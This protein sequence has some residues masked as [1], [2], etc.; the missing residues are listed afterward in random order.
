MST[1]LDAPSQSSSSSSHHHHRPPPSS[2]LAA[3]PPEPVVLT[4]AT[5]H[6]IHS[7]VQRA[8]PDD[9]ALV[10][11]LLNNYCSNSNSSNSRNS[12]N[13]R[14]RRGIST[15]S[16]TESLSLSWSLHDRLIPCRHSSLM[17]QFLRAHVGEP[18]NDNDND[19]DATATNHHAAGGNSSNSNG[20]IRP[21]HV[22]R[23]LLWIPS[24]Y[25]TP[26]KAMDQVMAALAATAMAR[27]VHGRHNDHHQN[28]HQNDDHSHSY[29][30]HNDWLRSDE[31]SLR[32]IVP[33]ILADVQGFLQQ[34]ATGWWEYERTGKRT[35]GRATAAATTTGSMVSSAWPK[36]DH[37][38]YTPRDWI[39]R[40]LK[41]IVRPLWLDVDHATTTT[42]AAK[43]IVDSNTPSSSK[44]HSGPPNPN[45][46]QQQ[47]ETPHPAQDW[48]LPALLDLVPPILALCR[49]FDQDHLLAQAL[50][51]LFRSSRTDHRTEP[52][53]TNTIPTTTTTTTTTTT[54]CLRLP[55]HP[56]G[57]LPWLQVASDVRFYLR[58]DDVRA[59]Q[60]TAQS[61]FL[62]PTFG[63]SPVPNNDD[64][65]DDDDANNSSLA[66]RFSP[67]TNT[68][69]V[70][71][72]SY[73]IN[74]QDLPAMT[75]AIVSL[76]L[77]T[78]TSAKMATGM[79]VPECGS[80]QSLLVRL[81][82]VAFCYDSGTYSAVET[83]LESNLAAL[84]TEIALA[85]TKDCRQSFEH[86]R[87]VAI[88]ASTT[89]NST[90][91]GNHQDIPHWIRCNLLL[92]L[93]RA[94]RQSGSQLVSRMVAKALGTTSRVNDATTGCDIPTLCWDGLVLLCFPQMT[95]N[96]PAATKRQKKKKQK[97]ARI[98]A[99]DLR[100][101]LKDA[102]RGEVT[103][104]AA[105]ALAHAKSMVVSSLFL[106][107]D[108]CSAVTEL[109]QT[110]ALE[111]GHAWV[112]AA[113]DVLESK[114]SSS[115]RGNH[116]E[117]LILA[118]V[119]LTTVFRHLPMSRQSLVRRILGTFS[120]D[121]SPVAVP[122]EVLSRFGLV[123]SL[124]I[125][126]SSHRDESLGE[127]C[128]E[129][130]V[131]ASVF[132]MPRIPLEEFMDLA[133]G[134][135]NLA[136]T[137]KSLLDFARK[138]VDTK[139]VRL[140]T[141]TVKEHCDRLHCG[142]FS[143]VVLLVNSKTWGKCEA[144]AWEM[145]SQ[146]IVLNKPFLPTS[147]R[148]W[149][150]RRI[151]DEVENNRLGSQASE[152][153]LRAC[154]VRMLQYF[155]SDG[156]KG[157]LSFAPEKLFL[158]WDASSVTASTGCTKQLE[159][160]VGLLRLTFALLYNTVARC[161][162]SRAIV[163]DFRQK[164]WRRLRVKKKIGES[165]PAE[166]FNEVQE[167]LF[168][169]SMQDNLESTAFMYCFC[170]IFERLSQTEMCLHTCN[171]SVTD[172]ASMLRAKEHRM[173]DPSLGHHPAWLE[174]QAQLTG[175]YQFRFSEPDQGAVDKCCVTL[176]DVILEFLLGQ[177]WSMLCRDYVLESASDVEKRYLSLG[178]C[179]I[180]NAKR[181]LSMWQNK[182][183]QSVY[184]E[185]D[186]EGLCDLYRTVL[187]LTL[188][189]V[190]SCI[191]S[192]VE[193]EETQL[194]V[195]SILHLSDV[196][197]SIF[198]SYPCCSHSFFLGLA[199]TLWNAY[200]ILCEESA[201]I[202]FISYV[203]K[204]R[205]LKIQLEEGESICGGFSLTAD[206]LNTDIR[207]IR[208]HV[209][210][211]LLKIIPRLDEPQPVKKVWSFS[212]VESPLDNRIH[213]TGL[214]LQWLSSLVQD[215]SVGLEGKSGGLSE[216][217]F[218]RFCDCVE[219][220]VNNVIAHVDTLSDPSTLHKIALTCSEA[221]SLAGA[222][223]QSFEVTGALA[224]KKILTLSTF[225]L[226]RVVS[227]A[228]RKALLGKSGIISSEFASNNMRKEN[229]FVLCL[230]QCCS[231]FERVGKI[232]MDPDIP[233]GLVLDGKLFATDEPP[234]VDA[235]PGSEAD[236]ES[237]SD[238]DGGRS[239]M[240]KTRRGKAMKLNNARSWAWAFTT[241][242]QVAEWMWGDSMSTL[243]TIE[244][245]FSSIDRAQKYLQTRR[246]ELTNIFE[247]SIW[248]LDKWPQ[249]E[250]K[251]S[252]GK[253]PESKIRAKDLPSTIQK[254]L[255]KLL[256]E[257]LAVLL[258]ATKVVTSLVHV[259]MCRL[260][261]LEAIE[262]LACL[263][264]WL[265]PEHSNFTTGIKEWYL[266]EKLI[267]N[268]AAQSD[269]RFVG[270]SDALGRL[271]KTLLRIDE[272]E[273]ALCRLHHQFEY[274]R[275][276]SQEEK[277]NR[278]TAL[279]DVDSIFQRCGERT[280][281]CNH[282]SSFG[283]EISIPTLV[284]KRVTQIISLR[285]SESRHGGEKR[286]PEREINSRVR[287]ERRRQVFRSRNV[288]VDKLRLMDHLSICRDDD[289]VE[290]PTSYDA[291]AEL[292]DF[293]V[294]G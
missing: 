186:V 81:L 65:D 14:R 167:P 259:E 53:R 264:V 200:L 231:I 37:E 234:N 11:S 176:F 224:L 271:S 240:I 73:S 145:L 253:F 278:K 230:K 49:D 69:V 50:D 288:A 198:E 116:P 262:A 80:W 171:P 97:A 77:A 172:L 284:A 286:R 38:P 78:C 156:R 127:S 170:G 223:L 28:D 153:L 96:S 226:P 236:D 235:G 276:L 147:S 161:D 141:W 279:V 104:E 150:F 208:L 197:S 202:K 47:S 282:A 260:L 182:T 211:I 130:E 26:W 66:G 9:P 164:L 241:S 128:R 209:L 272:V 20:M 140:P 207:D 12:N 228:N 110:Q 174:D 180:V 254:Q 51:V 287:K 109:A 40:I 152:H 126:E 142:L 225:I 121:Q 155:Q 57:L 165:D 181:E 149:L 67:S 193:L 86:E 215:L 125:E 257:M 266:T 98:S 203:E 82:F 232:G 4:R 255:N 93:F 25:E 27:R 205:E 267:H 204:Q 94:R 143:L 194:L 166:I 210:G 244:A 102:G 10:W 196:V 243:R 263:S 101:V 54:R 68:A 35:R 269:Q 212:K 89:T 148:S 60:Q 22:V 242:L 30:S 108:K 106:G 135:A 248:L 2:S 163:V 42:P 62:M 75:Q 15:A 249:H 79:A 281:A 280:D 55:I 251:R 237:G 146:I 233:W 41:H 159:D 13:S 6:E 46:Q 122:G 290:D 113:A 160:F 92:L 275:L 114:L 175:A 277:D 103:D 87:S 179:R 64:D 239:Q 219:Q 44:R 138:Q 144:E 70:S 3:T 201:V 261:Q 58:A 246:L 217:L 162:R 139:H 229:F 285:D 188:C 7:R 292:E 195:S 133:R 72:S 185:S 283:M 120:G 289:M 265:L 99:K 115:N 31:S 52:P 177:E 178:L 245:E 32:N 100:S 270:E 95:G 213:S 221:G 34:V 268:E 252:K 43:A 63:Q 184:D 85:W 19:H 294:D 5:L 189:T 192:E 190:Q 214:H 74:R 17:E 134:L 131:L 124:I 18:S 218:V 107:D 158:V 83:I 191:L 274:L 256:D 8:G 137:R 36:G 105:S 293:L 136:K 118:V 59:I 132:S 238:C 258:R 129:L 291:Y 173:L 16:G 273:S 112:H 29:H 154:V 39:V 151:R 157:Q 71:N 56:P 216:T 169:V 23:A 123:V 76:S 183:E 222:V 227:R 48:M 168:A 90:T 45:K 88:N 61:I 250:K 119:I 199:E 91:W 21:E 247:N 117:D 1:Q 220:C 206:T 111:R 84:P 187:E 24:A 33:S